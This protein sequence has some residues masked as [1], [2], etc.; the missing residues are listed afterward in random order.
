MC[1]SHFVL[2]WMVTVG[3]Y[4]LVILISRSKTLTVYETFYLRSCHTRHAMAPKEFRPPV[5]FERLAHG[6]LKS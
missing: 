1:K 3:N 6:E 2:F 5:L 4:Y